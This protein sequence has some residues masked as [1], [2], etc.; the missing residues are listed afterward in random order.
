MNICPVCGREWPA[1]AKFCPFDGAALGG[2]AEAPAAGSEE[3]EMEDVVSSLEEST[4]EEV[5]EET[6]STPET[7]KVAAT[8]EPGSPPEDPAEEINEDDLGKFSETSWFMAAA[9]LEGLESD[10]EKIPV[11]EE[12]YRPDEGIQSEIRRKFSLRDEPD[13]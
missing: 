7:E 13:E 1:A 2:D 5:A 4:P 8:P 10:L 6:P 3:A 9:D 12:K 11:D